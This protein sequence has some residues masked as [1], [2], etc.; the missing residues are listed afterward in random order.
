MVP[1]EIPVD[2]RL[3]EI[4]MRISST[5]L[6]AR[7]AISDKMVCKAERLTLGY[8]NP[9]KKA[10]GKKPMSLET[11]DEWNGLM[12]HVRDGLEA[13]NAKNKGKGGHQKPECAVT[14]VDLRPD[15][16]SKVGVC[17]IENVFDTH[18]H[19]VNQGG[20]KAAKAKVSKTE[21]DSDK[22][23]GEKSYSRILTEIKDTHHCARCGKPCWIDPGPPVTHRPFSMEQLSTWTSLIVCHVLFY[24][25]ILVDYSTS[26]NL[27]LPRSR[28]FLIVY[29]IGSGGRQRILQSPMHNINQ[30]PLQLHLLQPQ[31]PI[32]G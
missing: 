11:V 9:F 14:L 31:V 15:I 30:H 2:G 6:E 7:I 10:A 17:F 27:V 25:S 28:M 16:S 12:Q 24:V 21:T 20:K 5:W 4:T 19:G 18:N 29:E 1:F 23:D 8:F 22:E 32:L 3:K 26:S 13:H